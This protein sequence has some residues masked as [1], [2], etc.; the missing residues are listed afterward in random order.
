MAHYRE[1]IFQ[2]YAFKRDKAGLF[3]EPLEGMAK[4]E[5]PLYRIYFFVE[6]SVCIYSAGSSG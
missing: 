3:T 4:G 2:W 5:A 6:V 1:K